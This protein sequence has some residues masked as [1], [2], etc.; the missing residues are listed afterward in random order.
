[1][2]NYKLLGFRLIT[3]NSS[4][5]GVLAGMFILSAAI[6]EEGRELFSGPL[7]PSYFRGVIDKIIEEGKRGALRALRVARELLPFKGIKDDYA[8][9]SSPQFYWENY[10]RALKLKEEELSDE[11]VVPFI[12]HLIGVLSAFSVASNIQK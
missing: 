2:K 11:V 4:H 5:L 7:P 10:M 1:V 6:R 8:F 12:S 3:E 9:L